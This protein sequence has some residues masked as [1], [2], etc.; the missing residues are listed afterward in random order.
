MPTGPSI[1]ALTGVFTWTP[2]ETQGPNS[3]T[4]DVIVSDGT[5]PDSETITVTSERPMV[6]VY[7]SDTSTNIVPEQMASLQTMCT[8]S[9]QA[10]AQRQ[11]EN[12]LYSRL[13]G[14]DLIHEF[15]RETL[16]R[17]IDLYREASKV[18]KAAARKS[19]KKAR[20]K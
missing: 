10:R 17:I 14:Y 9:E 4:F 11:A 2:T 5:T 7:K 8:N 19:A 1:D 6:D 3:Y 13:G 18:R 15:T 16:I 12:A 20:K